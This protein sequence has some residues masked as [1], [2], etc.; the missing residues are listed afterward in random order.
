M[1]PFRALRPLS[2]AAP[3]V[4]APPYDVV[5]REEALAL[6]RDNPLSFLHVSRPEIDLP[7]VDPYDP[8]VYAKGAENFQRLI[9]EGVLR[10]D[11]APLFYVYRLAMGEHVQT[12]LVAVASVKA[13]EQGRIRRHE[14]TRPEK[15]M[16][17]IRHIEALNAQTGPVLLTFRA[18]PE[19]SALLRQGVEGEPVYDFELQGVRHT[20][21]VME[22]GAPLARHFEAMERLYIADGHHR[23][24]AAAKVAERRRAQNPHPTGEES[25]EYFLTVSFPH[26]EMQ[27]FP[28]H[29]VVKD[30]NGLDEEAFL[31]KVKT[32]FRVE[33]SRAPV[34]PERRGVFGMYLGGRWYRLELPDIRSE[35]PV[36]RLDVYLLDR[37]LLAPILGIE[38][39]RRDPRID[40]V[41][42]IRGLSALESRVDSGEMAVAFA[43]H[44]TAIE[45]LMAVADAGKLMP[46]KSTWFEPKL[47]DGLAC[48]ILD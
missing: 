5:S 30:L 8:R 39:P 27:I 46:P 24:A 33:P 7:G 36:E 6:A 31:E 26:N 11:D 35:D 13:Y 18:V 23:S 12:G 43:L 15:E 10:R 38:D 1:R 19:V 16:D 44:P 29:R 37:H 9:R 40:F 3:K 32:R 25:Y 41:G 14:L 4:A 42:G 20:F 34:Q 2:E 21:W 48:H 45:D 47:A 17:R 22:D 28:Y